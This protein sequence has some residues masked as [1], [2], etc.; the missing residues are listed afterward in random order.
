MGLNLDV[1]TCDLHQ[2][3]D[4]S[5]KRG[6]DECERFYSLQTVSV[7][8]YSLMTVFGGEE[9]TVQ[10]FTVRLIPADNDAAV[11]SLSVHKRESSDDKHVFEISIWVKDE[12]FSAIEDAHR[13]GFMIYHLIVGLYLPPFEQSDTKKYLVWAELDLDKF[14]TVNV[15]RLQIIYEHAAKK[16]SNNHALL[17]DSK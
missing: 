14:H 15:T 6:A 8:E 16:L 12:E 9:Q 1:I 2:N 17:I 3:I 10:Y 7:G 4:L 13:S 11:G 5:I